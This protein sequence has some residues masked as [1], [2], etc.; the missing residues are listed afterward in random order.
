MS[1]AGGKAVRLG[2]GVS[3]PVIPAK[4]SPVILADPHGA[5]SHGLSPID[6]TRILSQG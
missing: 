2:L 6:L 4:R 5:M 3:H 1:G